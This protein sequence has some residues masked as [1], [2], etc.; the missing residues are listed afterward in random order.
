MKAL[1]LYLLIGLSPIFVKGQPNLDVEINPRN[2]Q[3]RL[4][5]YAIFE[6]TNHARD[7]LGFS[8]LNNDP[9]LDTAANYQAYRMHQELAMQHSWRRDARFGNLGKRIKAFGGGFR[10]MGENI[11]RTFILNVGDGEYYFIDER[12][13]P[14]DKFGNRILNKT[15]RQLGKEAVRDWLN[16]PGHRANLL[17]AFDFLGVGV[18]PLVPLK[19]G[20]NFDVYLCQNFGTK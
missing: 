12:G 1:S 17:G 19:K 3:P 13:M 11:A 2:F 9:V 18:S 15:Y 10:G 8:K 7:S 20:P 6:E 16:S 4:L 14:M 5:A